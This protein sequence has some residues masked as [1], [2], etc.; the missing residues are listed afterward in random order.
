MASYGTHHGL[1]GMTGTG[2]LIKNLN[3]NSTCYILGNGDSGSI[4]GHNKGTIDNCSSA[5][6]VNIGNA[7]VGGG[8]CGNNNAGSIINC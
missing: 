8:I 6:I 2:S 7:E 3:L 4:V 1:F 5:A